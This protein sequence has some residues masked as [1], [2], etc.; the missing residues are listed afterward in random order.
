[1]VKADYLLKSNTVFAGKED[2][3]FSGAVAVK[4]NKIIKV[5]KK[6]DADR[7]EADSILDYGNKLIMPGFVDTHVHYFMGP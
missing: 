1:M 6:E 7:Y 4:G 5:M 3:S 2:R